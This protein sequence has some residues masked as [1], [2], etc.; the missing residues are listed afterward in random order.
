[1]TVAI[2]QPQY[3]PWMPYFDKMD[4]CD[5][6]VYLD[7]VQF[8]KNGVQNRNQIKTA[9]GPI[10]LT[11]PVR[12][13]LSLTIAETPI[14]DNRWQK[15]HIQS[16]EQNY[17]KASAASWFGERIKPL[18]QRDWAFLGELNVEV[19]EVMCEQLGIKAKR[20][21]ASEMAARGTNEELVLAICSELGAT[22]YLSGT[23]AR[24]YQDEQHF[25]QRGIELRYQSYQPPAYAQCFPSLGFVPSLSALDLILN[26][27]QAARE[28]LRGSAISQS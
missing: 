3:L 16:I 8:Q 24:M 7:N 1:M 4:S 23:G 11:V 25:A 20:V 2:H 19:T 28:I 10:W 26:H 22:S 27:G 21:R 14:A 6:F 12:A 5:V 18:L 9:Q 15:K 13:S 17:A